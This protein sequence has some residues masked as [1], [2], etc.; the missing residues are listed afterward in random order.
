[1]NWKTSCTLAATILLF[2]L[3]AQ[4][5]Q[6]FENKGVLELKVGEQKLLQLPTPTR[7]SVGNPQV[8]DV[9]V[10][11]ERAV[12]L[13]AT[14][15]GDTT[16]LVTFQKGQPWQ[17]HVHVEDGLKRT[18]VVIK[19]ADGHALEQL[20]RPYLTRRGQV[21]FER[22]TRALTLVDEATVVEVML[23]M[24]DRFDVKPA[25]VQLVLRLVEAN[26]SDQ[27]APLPPEIE[28]VVEQIQQVLRYNSF[29]VADQAFVTFEANG[30]S[31]IQVGGDK[32]YTV[33][34]GSEAIA[35]QDDSVR[36][37]FHLFRRQQEDAGAEGTHF[38]QKTL[39]A[40]TV[41]LKDGETAVLGASK[42][43]GGG[44]A[45]ITVVSLKLKK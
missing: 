1:M 18:T 25:Q 41:E 12:T 30:E 42:I 11:G 22:Q 43:N 35:G 31:R 9:K 13:F 7:V 8:A 5:E 23:K 27:P 10:E 19:H 40:T 16:L 2:A 6:A 4:A 38:I 15:A 45:L 28:P 29:V 14:G 24:V 37:R 21:R 34:V 33:E 26:Q 3:S 39:I 20:L 17:Y 36:L 32:A 44:K